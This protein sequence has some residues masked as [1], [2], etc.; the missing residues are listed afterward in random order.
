[1]Y[2]SFEAN[3]V[4]FPYN[5]SLTQVVWLHVHVNLLMMLCVLRSASTEY[6]LFDIK[7]FEPIYATSLISIGEH[8]R[9]LLLKTY[10][11][12]GTN[13]LCNANNKL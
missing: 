13:H 10:I 7:S 8:D 3:F 11:Y 4:T 5:C 9:V 2:N 12:A 1:M 6:A